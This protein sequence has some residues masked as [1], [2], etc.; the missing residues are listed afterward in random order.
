MGS[1]H[2]SLLRHHRSGSCDVF[3]NIILKQYMEG[4]SLGVSA[5]GAQDFMVY[6]RGMTGVLSHDLNHQVSELLWITQVPL[7]Q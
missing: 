2:L 6:L 4:Q 1:K 3:Y 5:L 7:L